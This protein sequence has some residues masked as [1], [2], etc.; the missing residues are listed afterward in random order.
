MKLKSKGSLSLSPVSPDR[1]DWLKKFYHWENDKSIHHLHHVSKNEMELSTHHTTFDSLV[2]RAEM[3][4]KSAHDFYGCL[5]WD[6]EPVGI[7]T[8]AVDPSHLWK[9][10]SKSFWPGIVIGESHARGKG[11]GR[12]TMLWCEDIAREMG[13]HRIELGVFEYNTIARR[14][15]V[16]LGYSELTRIAQF[17][18]WD[19]KLWS[20]IRMEKIII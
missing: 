3:A 16:S 4:S 1:T 12:Q 15:Y 8:G 2:H 10:E 20:D 7:L 13:C 5:L 9:K 18:W 17:T 19:G 11:A 14:L 6:D